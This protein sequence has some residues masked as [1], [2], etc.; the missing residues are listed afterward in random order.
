ML[1]GAQRYP[2]FTT[3]APLYATNTSYFPLIAGTPEGDH[4]HASETRSGCPGV[5]ISTFSFS[6]KLRTR[7]Y[8]D[9]S[10]KL[11]RISELDARL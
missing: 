5:I 4:H 2:F 9:L 10:D 1:F 6:E 8:G 11:G 7:G 3:F